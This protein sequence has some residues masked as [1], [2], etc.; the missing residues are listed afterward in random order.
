M[1]VSSIPYTWIYFE[2]PRIDNR[3]QNYKSK[4]G[5]S[6]KKIPFNLKGEKKMLRHISIMKN[7]SR[8][9]WGLYIPWI[10]FLI[11]QWRQNESPTL[12]IKPFSHEKKNYRQIDKLRSYLKIHNGFDVG[13][14][15]DRPIV[16]SRTEKEQ[17]NFKNK[18]TDAKAITKDALTKVAREYYL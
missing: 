6:V 1:F 18:L 12:N 2:C 5:I 7:I 13:T 14:T 11:L 16:T 3:I 9:W 4:H 17:L 8:L 10:Q 15:S